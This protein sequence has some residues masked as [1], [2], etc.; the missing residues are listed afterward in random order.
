MLVPKKIVQLKEKKMENFLKIKVQ[1]NN[2][3][4]EM[5]KQWMETDKMEQIWK[6]MKWKVMME[7]TMLKRG[8][9]EMKAM[10][11]RIKKMEQ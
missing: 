7:T 11:L 2:K 9:K 4:K 8:M 5:N 1:S 10:E 6:E 3:M